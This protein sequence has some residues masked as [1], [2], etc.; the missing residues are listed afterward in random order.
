MHR[1]ENQGVLLTLVV[2]QGE[3][4][5]P[6]KQSHFLYWYWEHA[7]LLLGLLVSWQEGDGERECVNGRMEDCV[8]YLLINKLILNLFIC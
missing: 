3:E 5:K 6:Q 4:R 2:N 7:K 8:Y 1:K